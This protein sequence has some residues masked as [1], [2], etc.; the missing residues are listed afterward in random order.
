M[1]PTSTT[2]AR[3]PSCHHP[4]SHVLWLLLVSLPDADTCSLVACLLLRT[5]WEGGPLPGDPHKKLLV[6][7]SHPSSLGRAWWRERGLLCRECARPHPPPTQK[8]SI[9]WGVCFCHCNFQK[10]VQWSTLEPLPSLWKPSVQKV[11]GKFHLK[12]SKG[13]PGKTAANFLAHTH[14]VY[15][16][17]L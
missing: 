2:K 12:K 11:L 8:A 7:Q 10:K 17:Q 9:A 14:K 3:S 16:C 4:L 13:E 5:H 1:S 15:F 6:P